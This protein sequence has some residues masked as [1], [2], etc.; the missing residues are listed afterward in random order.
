M[1]FPAF[2][3]KSKTDYLFVG[4]KLLYPFYFFSYENLVGNIETGEYFSL[5]DWKFTNDYQS[6]LNGKGK[7]D[8]Y[9]SDI[10]KINKNQFRYLIQ[11]K[12][13]DYIY[14]F[15]GQTK[16][17]TLMREIIFPKIDYIAGPIFV[18]ATTFWKINTDN[19]LVEITF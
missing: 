1:K 18:N 13:K 8:Y 19:E 2:A 14:N 16:N 6:I 15:D 12:D 10:K 5:N 17:S 4:G 3:V 11:F 7:L 9:L